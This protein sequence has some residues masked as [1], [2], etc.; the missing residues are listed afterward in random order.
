[1]KGLETRT[2]LLIADE[3]IKQLK[4]LTRYEGFGNSSVLSVPRCAA[5]A[6]KALTR[7]EGFG[8][9]FWQRR[10]LRPPAG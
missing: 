10:N 8:N 9:G 5:N 1:M 4:A 6:L 2:G 3:N 7:Y